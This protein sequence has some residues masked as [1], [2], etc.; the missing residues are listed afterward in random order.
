MNGIANLAASARSAA[1]EGNAVLLLDRRRRSV[2]DEPSDASLGSSER[3]PLWCAL[4]LLL[5]DASAALVGFCVRVF[6]SFCSFSLDTWS[7]ASAVLTICSLRT[8]VSCSSCSGSVR[9]CLQSCA[10]LQ[11]FG[12]SILMGPQNCGRCTTRTDS[13]SAWA[14]TFLGHSSSITF[15]DSC[16]NQAMPIWA[17]IVISKQTEARPR[18]VPQAICA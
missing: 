4:P 11:F 14:F 15:V 17:A 2:W 10:S 16:T 5:S 18:A 13:P 12:T 6:S 1:G 7:P 9:T 3:S 8:I